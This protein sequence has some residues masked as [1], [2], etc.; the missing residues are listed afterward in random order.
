MSNLHEVLELQIVAEI[1]YQQR[2][3][4]KTNGDLQIGITSSL[5]TTTVIHVK[6]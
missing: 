2:A 4:S 6:Y 3:I 5:K 1:P